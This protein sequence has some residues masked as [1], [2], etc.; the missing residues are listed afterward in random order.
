MKLEVKV[1]LA[2]KF[3]EDHRNKFLT[4]KVTSA[5]ERNGLCVKSMVNC[6]GRRNNFLNSCELMKKTFEMIEECDLVIIEFS[7]KGVGLGIEAGY[8][9]AIQ[10]PIIVIAKKGLEISNT[11]LGIAVRVSYYE[12][13]GDLE[14]WAQDLVKGC[15]VIKTWE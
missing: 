15:L 8:A 11:L 7:E 1:Y 9:Y 3:Y 14:L 4:E 12:R 6:E 2:A 5:L 10:K 13:I